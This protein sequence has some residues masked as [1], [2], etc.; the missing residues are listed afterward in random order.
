MDTNGLI[1]LGLLILTFGLISKRIQ[2]SALTPPMV[3]VAFGLAVGSD[4]LGLVRVSAGANAV[5]VFAELTLAVV[6]FLDASRINLARLRHEYHLPLRL[7]AFGMP[8]TLLL[9]TL[10]AL[11]LF[12]D[13][14]LFEA[15]LLA[16]ILTPTD[17]ALGQAVVS[18]PVVP[19]R[20]RQTLNVESCLNDG[21]ALPAVLILAALAEAAG[22]AEVTPWVGYT[23]KQI[24]LGPIV[25]VA[26]GYLGGKI[27]QRASQTGWM[28]H[29]FQELAG[30]A[31]AFLAFGGAGAVGGNGFI[32]TFVA[33]L[34]LG[35]TSRAVCS[36][37]YEF[38]EVEGQLL[39]LVTFSL[40][41][42]LLVG[43]S[44][45]HWTGKIVLYAAL[46]LTLVRM[47]PVALG[48][49][50]AGLRPVSILFLGWFGPRGLASILFGLLIV[51][52]S[53]I[54]HREEIFAGVIA[55]VLASVVL[56]GATA[57]PAARA[58]GRRVEAL[59]REA[60]V[61]PE[62]VSVA[63]MPVR[64]SHPTR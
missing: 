10:L 49:I 28:N 44:V 11:V 55:T 36:C 63:E 43:P 54:P 47:A 53:G 56:H 37:L 35:N 64:V 22:Q 23:V 31:L 62:H 30:L 40:F 8:L 59:K 29:S 18:D 61:M 39:V 51:E 48:L 3:F 5:H 38:T 32:A 12:S 41:G 7:L 24:A 52:R 33:G 9:G 16:A 13:L 20:I 21:L 27:I 58:Y 14:S 46:S 26:V 50:G 6:L 4:G 15:A 34:T 60:E 17:A 45:P 2:M 1:A 57:A 42:A 19:V 25:G